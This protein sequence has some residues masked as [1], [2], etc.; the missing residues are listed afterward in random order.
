MWDNRERI[1]IKPR[2][3][4]RERERERERIVDQGWS[5]EVVEDH[6][7]IT[8]F[9]KLA[10]TIVIVTSSGLYILHVFSG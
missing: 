8:S 2:S 10:S 4:E 9:K 1:A 7:Y 5:S 6:L 3:H